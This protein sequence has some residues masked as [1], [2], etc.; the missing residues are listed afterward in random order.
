MKIHNAAAAVFVTIL[1]L[2][3]SARSDEVSDFYGGREVRLLIG[4][5]AGGGYDTYARLLA[6][7]IGRH[8]PGNPSV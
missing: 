1:V 6:R 2:Q 8:I 7:H 4:Y 5:S 3:P